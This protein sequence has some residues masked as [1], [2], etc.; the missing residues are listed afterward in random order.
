[1]VHPGAPAVEVHTSE[2]VCTPFK[3]PAPQSLT[4][5]LTDTLVIVLPAWNIWLG[6]LETSREV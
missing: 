4:P 3:L 5:L 2:L 6:I 1:M